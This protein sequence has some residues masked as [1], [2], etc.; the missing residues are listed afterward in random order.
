MSDCHKCHGEEL[1]TKTLGCPPKVV[2][3]NNPCCPVIFHR[4]DIPAVMGDDT[5]YPPENGLYKNVLLVYE[6]NGNAY[7]YSSDGV[8]TKLTGDIEELEKAIEELGIAVDGLDQALAEEGEERL[9]SDIA[10]REDIDAVAEDLEEFKNNP[11]VVDIVATYTDLQAYDTS[12]LGDK[13]IIRV[14]TDE[15]HDDE[16]SY[17]RWST[18]TS[19][20]TFI[21]ATGPYYTKNETDALLDEKQ[22]VLTAGENIAIENDTI[23]ADVGTTLYVDLGEFSALS[24]NVSAPVSI[25]K[26]KGL[27]TLVTQAEMWEA[28]YSN[29]VV[30]LATSDG[31]LEDT[32]QTYL[33]TASDDDFYD[34]RRFWFQ[35]IIS[36]WYRENYYNKVEF[37]WEPGAARPNATK[38]VNVCVRVAEV[39]G[40]THSLTDYSI[41]GL[42]E[43]RNTGSTDA[44]LLPK[45]IEGDP[46]FQL[47]IKPSHSVYIM[48]MVQTNAGGQKYLV[49]GATNGSSVNVALVE[50][51]ATSK[52]K[53]W[54][55]YTN[56]LTTT[57]SD[58]KKVLAAYQGYVLNNRIG[59]L[60]TLQTTAKTSTVAAI[61]ELAATP[62]AATVSSQDWSSLWQ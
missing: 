5:T 2:Q 45:G 22:D 9:E 59:D 23:S 25:Y 53:L 37:T 35:I 61:N 42:M 16:S 46:D 38:R 54:T 11:D 47:R 39:Q 3:I 20:W 44:L 36:T 51:D 17:Y 34:G 43:L 56:N 40:G 10:L 55:Q 14:L 30:K 33:V 49:F 62:G 27:T 28:L 1:K 12:A 48:R 21:G 7:L 18:A 8:P 32:I 41:T 58:G 4:V 24:L 19:T 6:A 26:D 31:T 50:P 29:K 13:D 60:S 57:N 52:I 15:T